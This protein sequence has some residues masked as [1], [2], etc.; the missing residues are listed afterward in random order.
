MTGLGSVP[1]LSWLTAGA[2]WQKP[3]VAAFPK[4]LTQTANMVPQAF[5]TDA[6]HLNDTFWIRADVESRFANVASFFNAISGGGKVAYVRCSL[7]EGGV[8]DND[9]GSL[10]NIIPGSWDT[11]RWEEHEYM[12]ACDAI[13]PSS[14]YAPDPEYVSFHRF[15]VAVNNQQCSLGAL[16]PG[17]SLSGADAAFWQG[18]QMVHVIC[19]RPARAPVGPIY[20]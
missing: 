8:A 14:Y 4:P 20:Q 13:N 19:A 12:T 3:N 15:V 9:P 10:L 6:F 17:T 18:Q 7:P 11:R 2:R 5:Y 1:G 16:V